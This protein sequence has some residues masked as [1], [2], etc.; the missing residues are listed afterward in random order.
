MYDI[1]EDIAALLHRLPPASTCSGSPPLQQLTADLRRKREAEVRVLTEDHQSADGS[2]PLLGKLRELTALKREIDEQLS[3][4]IVYSRH[5]VR[6]RPYQ[7]SLIAKATDLSI[8]GV[9]AIS[10][11]EHVM[12]EVARNLGRLDIKGMLAPKGVKL[13]KSLANL[14]TLSPKEGW[15]SVV[16]RLAGTASSADVT[17]K[18][19]TGLQMLSDVK[20]PTDES[21]SFPPGARVRVS[22][23]NR[24][25]EGSVSCEIVVDGR[26][27]SRDEAAGAYAIASC[28]GRVP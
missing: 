20:L 7:L 15:R 13:E 25:A 12:Q 21:H 28:D 5:F 3:H 2:D 17:M 26:L 22:M 24:T 18:T 10:S 27:I 16:Y 14:E 9:R 1:F 4:L 19:E 6:P 11:R 23:R 8:S